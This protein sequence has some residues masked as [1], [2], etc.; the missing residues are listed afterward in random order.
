[1]LQEVEFLTKSAKKGLIKE[2]DKVKQVC[3]SLE[4]RCPNFC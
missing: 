2:F 3:L 1:M 4:K